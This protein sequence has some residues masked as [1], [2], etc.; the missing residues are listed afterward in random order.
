MAENLKIT[1]VLPDRSKKEVEAPV[2]HTIMEIAKNNDI[3]QI[4]ALCGGAKAC[5]TCH[6][7]LPRDIYEMLEE[8]K[9]TRK[10]EEE[11]N[12]LDLAFN[13]EATSRLGCQVFMTPEMDKAKINV[14][15]GG[16]NE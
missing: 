1:F 9:Q 2:D 12:I 7:I 16:S 10:T 11:E 14:P 4:E 15:R 8:N 5:A 13:V 6:V 3:D